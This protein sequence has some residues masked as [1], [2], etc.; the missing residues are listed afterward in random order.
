MRPDLQPGRATGKGARAASSSPRSLARSAR[1]TRARWLASLVPLGLGLAVAANCSP[2]DRGIIVDGSQSSDLG[3]MAGAG[4]EGN[5]SGG[6][7]SG[8]AGAGGTDGTGN[9]GTGDGGASG[10]TASGGDGGSQSGGGGTGGGTMTCSDSDECPAS[11]PI[12]DESE[13]ECRTC[14]VDDECAE[15]NSSLPHCSGGECVECTS[16]SQC[17]A[18]KPVCDPDSCRVC[19]QHSE[20]ASGACA[21]DGSCVPS[22]QIVYALAQTGSTAAACGTDQAPCRFLDDAA[23]QLAVGRNY[24]VLLETQAAFDVASQML[25][26]AGVD[27]VVLGNGVTIQDTSD[28]LIRVTSGTVVLE[29]LLVKGGTSGMGQT[30]VEVVG[31]DVTIRR[32]SFEGGTTG[33]DAVDASVHVADSSFDVPTAGVSLDCSTD[34]AGIAP[35]VVERSRFRN[36]STAAFLAQPGAIFANNLVIDVATASYDRGVM[37]YADQTTAMFNTLIRSGSCLYTGLFN[38]SGSAGTAVLVGNI[39]YEST[40]LGGGPC[41]DQIYQSCP[42]PTYSISEITFA[43]T[44]NST[45]DPAFVDAAGG[46]FRLSSGSPAEDLVPASADYPDVDILGNPRPAGTGYDAGAYERQ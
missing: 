30:F 45:Q 34:C 38:C 23:A 42:N 21:P 41:Y 1:P 36:M 39:T 33:V 27:V 14:D 7:S 10:G 19:A 15:A 3:G 5:A 2:P 18:E 25:L 12:C 8:G 43:G 22:S 40:S 29:D 37:L 28:P 9:G 32:S 31:G 46:D 24:L 16:S 4:A 44:G 17:P 11:A 26:P 6:V 35:S 13:S 20:C